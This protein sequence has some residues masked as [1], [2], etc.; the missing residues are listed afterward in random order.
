MTRHR[1]AKNA[2]HY[3][4][5]ASPFKDKGYDGADRLDGVE[6]LGR[7][8]RNFPALGSKRT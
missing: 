6:L 3:R 7:Y 5:T 2:G 1:E 4:Q 8:R